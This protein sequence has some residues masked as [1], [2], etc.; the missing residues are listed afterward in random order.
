M[1]DWS[2]RLSQFTSEDSKIPHDVT[3]KIEGENNDPRIP[4]EVK[5]HKMI[6]SMAS[7]VFMKM[8]Y[9]S[10]TLDKSAQLIVVRQTTVDAF[11]IMVHAIYNTT[12]LEES[13]KDKS[14]EEMFLVLD[15]VMKYQIPELTLAARECL[16]DVPLTDDTVLEVAEDAEQYSTVFEEEAKKV[17]FQCAKFLQQKFKDAKSV[18]K[19]V[20]ENK[21]HKDVAYNLL[22]MID[23]LENLNPCDNCTEMPCRDGLVVE[24]NKFRSGL[25]IS[26]NPENQWWSGTADARATVEYILQSKLPLAVKLKDCQPGR[27]LHSHRLNASGTFYV[28]SHGTLRFLFYCKN[29]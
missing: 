23:T 26:S 10:D 25:R 1:I 8:F 18:F 16:A 9:V 3:F 2:T 19:F 7:P 14:V 4:Q 17:L 6:L 11:R 13:L 22:A 29:P 15:L 12:P 5:A 28:K 21:A 24:E 20:A 27:G